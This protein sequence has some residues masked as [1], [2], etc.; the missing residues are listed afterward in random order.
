MKNLL[1]LLVLGVTL[2]G[3]SAGAQTLAEIAKESRAKQKANP[4]AKVI[5]NDVLPSS[6]EAAAPDDEK[7]ADEKKGDDKKAD[8]K[9]SGDEKKDGGKEDKKA[10]SNEDQKNLDA[11]KKR[12]ADQKKEISQLQRE[13]DVAEREAR[14]RAA[15]Y[16]ADAGVQFRDQAKYAEDSRNLQTEIDT[17]KQALADAKQRLEDMQDEARK[18]GVPSGQLN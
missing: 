17:K 12:L 6:P 15:A 4:F 11:W 13:L 8:E 18:A 1:S 5:D 10:A 2:F 9:K 7:K 14:L 16:Y 3:V